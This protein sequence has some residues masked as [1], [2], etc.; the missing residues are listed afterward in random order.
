M[1]RAGPK[2]DAGLDSLRS[3]DRPGTLC[4]H[5]GSHPDPRTG[6]VGTPIYQASTFVLNAKLYDA[7]D[8]GRARDGF[9]YGRYGTPNQ[10]A[11]QE[12]LAALEG[13]ESGV[14][15][16]SG[17]AAISSTLMALLDPGGHVVSSSDLYG[18][19]YGF[20]EHELP[21]TGMGATFVDPRDLKGLEAVIRPETQVLYTEVLSNPLLKLADVRAMAAICKRHGLWLVV[22][23]T[24]ATPM[25]IQALK[26]GADVVVHSASKYLN[27]HSDLIA[28]AALG[29]R[30][31]MD[32]VWSRMLHFGGSLDAHACFLLERGLKTLSIRMRAHQQGALEI[33]RWLQAHPL[34]TSVLYPGLRS[35][36]DFELAKETLGNTGGVVTF[37][38]KGGDRAALGVANALR[39]PI[40]ATSLGGVE[41][42]VSLPFNTSHAP[43]TP[44]QRVGLGIPEGCLRLSVGIEDP[45]DLVADLKQ[46]LAG[47][48]IG[49][50]YL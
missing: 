24:F 31:L 4:V 45:D 9:I 1:R 14:V 50:N 20:F 34:V 10:W 18:G 26:L 12:K 8:G 42:L 39:I 48:D 35:H 40:Q 36:P 46:A 44:T 21:N 2:L 22:D 28:G 11:V 47:L 23:S 49:Q 37:S 19:T 15:F 7:V 38:I 33:A 43:F 17:M 27:G 16:S 3:A 5:A 29:S 32:R 13:A 41:S 30:K 25:G 6:A